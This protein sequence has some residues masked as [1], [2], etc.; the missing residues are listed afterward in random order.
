[1]GRVLKEMDAKE[2]IGSVTLIG[3][4]TD[5]CVISNAMIARAFLPNAHITVDS[6]A[7]AGVTPESHSRA[8]KAMATCQV[9]II[10]K[11]L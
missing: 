4:C 7:C 6:D 11:N 3:L 8:L 1:L 5:I 10:G 2:P 9:E